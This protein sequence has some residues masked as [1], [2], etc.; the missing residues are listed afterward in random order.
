MDIVTVIGGG[1]AGCEAA[2]QIAQR[3]IKVI[4]YEMRPYKTTGAHETGLL[5]ELVCS[6][7]LGSN[8]VDKASGLIKQELRL[9]NSMLIRSADNTT[10]AAGEALAVDRNLFANLVTR[11]IESHSNIVVERKEMTE[12]PSGVVIIATGPLTSNKFAKSIERILDKENLFFYDAIAPIVLSRTI[13]MS[14][15]FRTSRYGKG[16]LNEGDYVNCPFD[17]NEY[18]SFVEALSNADTFPIKDFEARILKGVKAGK[19]KYFEACLPI[20]E[21]GKRGDKTLAFGPMRPVGITN[22]RTGERP[23]AVAQLRNEDKQQNAY[24]L[25]GFQTNLTNSEQERIFRMIPGLRNAV[26][27]R[28][29]RMHRN[30]FIHSPGLMRPT[31]QMI[32]HENIF[33]AGQIVGVEGYCANIAAGFLAGINVVRLIKG[34]ELIIFPGDTL[35]GSLINKITCLD[36]ANFQPVKANMGLLGEGGKSRIGKQ[37]RRINYS[38]R[39]LFSMSNFIQNRVI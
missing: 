22:P 8:R 39:A 5:A 19:A 23:Y 32:Q 27:V 13:D 34:E 35:I 28:Y 9:L 17:E 4:L 24:N 6:N 3:G 7:S 15:A 1:L 29:G 38:Q 31:L 25:V 30:T 16:E 26:F 20:E 21:L 14:I 18:F 36:N 37:R 11:N 10:V 12:I 2:W 33:V